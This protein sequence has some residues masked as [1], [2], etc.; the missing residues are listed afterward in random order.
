MPEEIRPHATGQ[1][2]A[3]ASAQAADH[4]AGQAASPVVCL[5]QCTSYQAVPLLLPD[6][7]DSTGLGPSLCGKTVLVKPNLLRNNPLA[8]THPAVV[9][10]TCSWLLDQGARVQV[11]DSPGFGTA[12]SVAAAIG[13]ETALKPLG[14]NVEA[15]AKGESVRLACGSVLQISRTALAADHIVS[16]A[17][18]KAH[19]QVR[20][21]LSCKNLYGCVPGLRKALYHTREGNTPEHFLRMLTDILKVL[22]PVAGVL[23]GVVAMH[24]TGPSGGDPFALGLLAASP[25]PVALDE[26]VLAALGRQCADSPLAEAF[27]QAGHADCRANGCTVH[28]PMRTPEDFLPEGFLLPGHLLHTSFRPWRLCKSCLTRLWLEH[29][30]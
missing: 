8:C 10:T 26:A 4:A 9:A 25:S 24:R 27:A 13:L 16:V 1:V 17:R 20:I 18:V 14:L 28:Y 23:D 3:Q 15:M 21:T 2:S 5:E 22:P 11:A 7:L 19:S 29:F 6:V 12:K 30:A